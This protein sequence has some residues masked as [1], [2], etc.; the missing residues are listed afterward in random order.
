MKHLKPITLYLLLFVSFNCLAQKDEDSELFNTLKTND[1]LLFEVGFNN[2]DL[3]QF[4]SLMADDLEFY[5]DKSGILNSVSQ[6]MEVMKTGICKPSNTYKARRELI[7]GS[8]QVFPLY[9]NGVLYGAIQ[10]GEH[11]FF[12][13][14]LDQP[15]KIGSLAK[16]T[17]LWILENNVWKLKRILSYDHKI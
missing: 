13:K 14:N 17:H 12:E 2:C 3:S 9:D 6:F 11:Q 15:E 1:S 5:H 4:E 16:F 7:K 8:L 10:T